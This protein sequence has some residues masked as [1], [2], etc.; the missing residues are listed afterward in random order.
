MPINNERVSFPGGTRA[1]QRSSRDIQFLR[2]TLRAT[3]ADLD[4]AFESDLEVVKSSA[5]DE[6]LKRPVIAKLQQRHRERR[7]PYV[8]QLAAL[9]ERIEAVAA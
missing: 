5:M 8:H 6:G 7:T 1:A 4:L 2:R 9:K 3:L